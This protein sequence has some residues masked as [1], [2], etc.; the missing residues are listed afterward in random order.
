MIDF[1]KLSCE[2]LEKVVSKLSAF[3]ESL[4]PESQSDNAEARELIESVQAELVDGLEETLKPELAASVAD[5][6]KEYLRFAH[7]H[8]P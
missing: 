3:F 2:Q 6:L 1:R 8:A 4:A 7:L 5:W